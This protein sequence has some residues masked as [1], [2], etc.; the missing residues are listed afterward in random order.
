MTGNG[1]QLA[2][3]LVPLARDRDSV[4]V[5]REEAVRVDVDQIRSPQAVQGMTDVIA[6]SPGKARHPV[7][8]QAWLIETVV[9]A[10]LAMGHGDQCRVLNF[11]EGWSGHCDHL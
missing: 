11:G 4:T 9:I 6:H 1:S 8:A 10:N 3:G 2:E 7:V 5:L